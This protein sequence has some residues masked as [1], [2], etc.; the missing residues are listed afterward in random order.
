MSIDVALSFF[1]CGLVV[2][3]KFLVKVGFL[4]FVNFFIFSL[5]SRLI[6]K[7]MKRGKV[8]D[9]RWKVLE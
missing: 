2:G 4:I 7:G 9:F 5:I 3:D 1:F 6:V 8:L